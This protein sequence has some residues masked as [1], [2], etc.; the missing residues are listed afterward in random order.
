MRDER[1]LHDRYPFL[2]P[3]ALDDIHGAQDVGTGQVIGAALF[4]RDGQAFLGRFDR[5]LQVMRVVEKARQ[6]Q[7]RGH[8]RERM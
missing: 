2:R 8:P 6:G 4:R 3:T 1:M 5:A 7:Q